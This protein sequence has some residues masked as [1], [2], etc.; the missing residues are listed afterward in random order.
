MPLL[1]AYNSD[2]DQKIVD[3]ERIEKE[4]L[5]YYIAATNTQVTKTRDVTIT[6]YRYVGMTQA[7]AESGQTTLNNP[8]ALTAVVRRASAAGEYCIEVTERTEG[9]WA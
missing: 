4:S 5:T 8:P 1:S 3:E 7:A 2:A 9:A 6:Q